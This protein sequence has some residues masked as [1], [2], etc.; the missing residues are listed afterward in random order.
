MAYENAD[1][2][3]AADAGEQD[4]MKAAVELVGWGGV[5]WD[6]VGVKLQNVGTRALQKLRSF[7]VVESVKTAKITLRNDLAGQALGTNSNTTSM[8]LCNFCSATVLTILHMLLLA[9]PES[10]SCTLQLAAA[11]GSRQVWHRRGGQA[12]TSKKL[13]SPLLAAKHALAALI[14]WF[15]LL[16]FL[17][18]RLL[19]RRGPPPDLLD[20]RRLCRVLQGPRAPAL[21]VC[22]AGV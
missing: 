1:D 20:W 13:P 8:G 17:L 14:F 5:G 16:C 10:C 12:T 2:D 4:L 21:R 22:G 15:W 18:G 7:I 19:C 3:A 6:G 11:K 9:A